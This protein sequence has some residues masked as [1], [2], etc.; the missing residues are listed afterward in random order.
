MIEIVYLLVLFENIVTRYLSVFSY[1]DE[2]TAIFLLFV[3]A[4]KALKPRAKILLNDPTK[5]VLCF[6]I[7][8]VI[9]L[10]STLVNGNLQDSVVA[11]LK[12][13]LALSKLPVIAIGAR[14]LFKH[15]NAEKIIRRCARVTRY[16]LIFIC[17]C[18]LLDYTVGIG[19]HRGVRIIPVYV[20]L[21]THAT[22]AVQAYILM[23]VV[24]IADSSKRNTL[25]ILACALLTLVTMRAKG[26]I[27]VA[28][29]IA[30]LINRKYDI[31]SWSKMRT[32]KERHKDPKK[33]PL[34]LKWRYVVVA[35]AVVLVALWDKI[36]D[37]LSWGYKAARTGLYLLGFDLVRDYFPLGTGFGTFASF[38]SGEYYSNVY[39]LYGMQ[40]VSGM[41]PTNYNYI[42]DVYW[43]CIYG[44]FGLFG[45]IAYVLMMFYLFRWSLRGLNAKSDL[46]Y[47]V[48]LLWLYAL[49]ASVA[50][51][52][53]TNSSVA[54]FALLLP[55]LWRARDMMNARREKRAVENK[56]KCN[57][58]S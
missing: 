36:G 10:I 40:N 20:F 34:R 37:Y 23:M 29:I 6:G 9:G 54:Q 5:A 33:V 18:A 11:K 56:E 19:M 31:I 17:V 27:C 12:D 14:Y 47:A 8:L 55:L 25:Y 49:V 13:V 53:F 45:F 39:Y 48:I 32:R 3:I 7:V 35:C 2:L 57:E 58:V 50:E 28:V 51:A 16:A 22:Y 26:I 15:R 4:V 44:Q 24:L 41:T 42:A 43:P 46:C 1:W 38:I 30:L 21:F 52:F